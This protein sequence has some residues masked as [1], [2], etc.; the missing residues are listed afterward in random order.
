MSDSSAASG[1]LFLSS[2]HKWKI[3]EQND[4]YAQAHWLLYILLRQ[5]FHLVSYIWN[6]CNAHL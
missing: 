4:I 5:E 6:V 2:H 1:A 3:C